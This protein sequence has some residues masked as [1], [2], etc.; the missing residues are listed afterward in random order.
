MSNENNDLQEM[1]EWWQNLSQEE[2]AVA[3]GA[4]AI[5]TGTVGLMAYGLGKLLKNEWDQDL[6]LACYLIEK[7]KSEAVETLAKMKKQIDNIG[8]PGH[9]FLF[10]YQIQQ[11]CAS[12]PYVDKSYVDDVL[13]LAETRARYMSGS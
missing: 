5:I 7:D 6:E 1:R 3:G 12:K 4:G 8:I 2:K 11:R 10:K 9:W 13:R